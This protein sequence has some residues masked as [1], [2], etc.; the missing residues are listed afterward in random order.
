MK[1]NALFAFLFF[2]LLIVALVFTAAHQAHGSEVSA[3]PAPWLPPQ[4]TPDPAPTS[5]D[6]KYC[7]SPCWWSAMPTAIPFSIPTQRK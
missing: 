7:V 4:F 5:T 6:A 1:R 2:L 3:T